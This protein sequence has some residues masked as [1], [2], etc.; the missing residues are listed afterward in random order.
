V[1]QRVRT[2]KNRASSASSA[3]GKTN[4]R[5]PTTPRPSRMLRDLR[6]CVTENEPRRTLRAQTGKE[7]LR[8]LRHCVMPIGAGPPV[9]IVRAEDQ[10][11]RSQVL[12]R[13]RRFGHP[14]RRTLKN[15]GGTRPDRRRHKTHKT[16]RPTRPDTHRKFLSVR[17][18]RRRATS[19]SSGREP[20]DNARTRWAEGITTQLRPSNRSEDDLASALCRIRYT[21]TARTRSNA[22]R[23]DHRFLGRHRSRLFSHSHRWGTGRP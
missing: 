23:G 15:A 19:Y 13:W 5:E 8:H 14:R 4:P 3:S 9:A 7:A 2:T 18:H 21:T 16:G 12:A 10:R 17:A 1:P 11:S 6:H 22:R 20:R